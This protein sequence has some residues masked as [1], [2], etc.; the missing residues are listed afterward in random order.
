M[1]VATCPV[2]P[3][4]E[5]GVI[6]GIATIDKV[7]DDNVRK[8]NYEALGAMI[9]YVTLNRCRTRMLLDYFGEK[10]DGRCGH[11]DSCLARTKTL[12]TGR[13]RNI[14]RLFDYC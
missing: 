6:P 1:I 14:K 8:G 12:R 10:L 3:Q 5:H 9:N 7:A 2:R 4:T 11:C 13:H